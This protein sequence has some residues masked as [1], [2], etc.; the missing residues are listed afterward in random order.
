MKFIENKFLNKKE[1]G[2]SKIFLKNGYI[3][4]NSEKFKNNELIKQELV[5]ISSK[6]LNKKIDLNYLHN[7]VDKKDIND[8]RVEVIRRINKFSS[9][10][11]KYFEIGKDH[12]YALAGNELVMQ[13][14]INLSIQLPD[15]ET[16]LLPIHS[17]VWS[18]DSPYEI[19]LWVPLVDCFKTKSMYILEQENIDFFYKMSKSKNLNNSEIIYKKLK[20]KLKWLNIKYGKAL[21]FNQCL[22]HGNIV[23][24]ENTTRWSMNCRFK[25]IF[26]SYGDKKIGEFFSPITTRAMTKIAFKYKFP[27]IKK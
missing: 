23:N 27:F 14:N 16:S 11:E 26:S 25:S 2:L 6:I 18:G 15:D 12:I 7:H 1:I 13:K 10:R 9:L 19:N 3:I 17:D 21:I 5:K 24:V 22:P 20:N 4:F 8:F